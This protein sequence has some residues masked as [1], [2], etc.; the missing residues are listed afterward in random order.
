VDAEV[1]LAL[2]LS[3]VGRTCPRGLLPSGRTFRG[4]VLV[5]LLLLLILT[6][7]DVDRD[8]PVRG[9]SLWTPVRGPVLLSRVMALI[10]L[11][12]LLLALPF[13]LGVFF[14]KNE[15]IRGVDFGRPALAALL[16]GDIVF[17]CAGGLDVL[18]DQIC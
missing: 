18:E 11:V 14:L 2:A 9:G 4:V 6:A 17:F 1:L 8:V 13:G 5:L 3:A 15:E 16:V 12:P 10:A 7:F